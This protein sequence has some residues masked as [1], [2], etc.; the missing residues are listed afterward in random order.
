M[1]RFRR[2]I[3]AVWLILAVNIMSNLV[4]LESLVLCQGYDGHVALEISVVD[5]CGASLDC[6]DKNAVS[7]AAIAG[8]H[9]SKNSSHCGTCT[10]TPVSNKYTALRQESKHHLVLAPPSVSSFTNIGAGFVS[11]PVLGLFDRPL[12]NLHATPLRI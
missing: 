11:A 5:S 9:D 4:G 12:F 8:L 3:T 2:Q 7:P 6:T 1:R 10:D